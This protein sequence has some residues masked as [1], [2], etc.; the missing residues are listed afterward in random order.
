MEVTGCW[1]DLKS[2]PTAWF[3]LWVVGG[4]RRVQ[5]SW[6]GHP[7]P[8]SFLVHSSYSSLF[9]ISYERINCPNYGARFCLLCLN[10]FPFLQP[11]V[12][13]PLRAHQGIRFQPLWLDPFAFLLSHL[14]FLP[15]ERINVGGCAKEIKAQMVKPPT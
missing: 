12:L 10:P 14:F 5:G 2:R 1:V 4:N 3:Y 8:V 11:S 15:Y 9:F 6:F 7:L 13:P